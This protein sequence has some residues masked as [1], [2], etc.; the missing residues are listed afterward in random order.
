MSPNTPS[1]FPRAG[2]LAA[3]VLVSVFL[4][5]PPAA[6]QL[7]EPGNEETGLVADAYR[8]LQERGL[9]P[10]TKITSFYTLAILNDN[11]EKAFSMIETSEELQEELSK[12]ERMR[13]LVEVTQGIDAIDLVAFRFYSTTVISLGYLVTTENGPAAVRLNIYTPG[14]KAV[15]HSCEIATE[16]DDM[17]RM[18]DSLTALPATLNLQLSLEELQ[19]E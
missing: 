9:Q 11:A 2:L 15:L 6:A 14:N 7:G 17:D 18:L 3:S 13:E 16:W 5:L 8:I 1:P 4:P 19:G 12:S 10:L